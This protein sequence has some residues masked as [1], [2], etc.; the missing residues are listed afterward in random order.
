VPTE[1]ASV[2]LASETD[3]QTEVLSGGPSQKLPLERA[4]D[5]GKPAAALKH[6]ARTEYANP[7]VSV[8]AQEAAPP[9]PPDE[10]VTSTER[11]EPEKQ[12]VAD[13]MS[14]PQQPYDAEKIGTITPEQA[15]RV[16]DDSTDNAHDADV[17]VVTEAASPRVAAQEVNG[18]GSVGSADDLV[19]I[20]GIGPK[21]SAALKAA[22][23][24]SF[25]K[26]ANTSPETLRTIINDAGV[27]LI[28]EID[29]WTQQASYAARGDWAGLDN[30]N[31]ER[32][33]KRRS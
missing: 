3:S 4:E 16:M 9:P 13:T 24:D 8:A 19:K 1:E 2:K 27:R 7:D 32:K 11:S 31:A 23:I 10:S 30:F 33:G 5:T 17:P 12:V 26:L 6:T 29:S 18:E 22:G 14:A 20:D 25:Q 21:I 28:G 15:A